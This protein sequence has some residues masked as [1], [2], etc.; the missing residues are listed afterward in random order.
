MFGNISISTDRGQ[1][2]AIGGNQVL[3]TNGLAEGSTGFGAGGAYVFFDITVSKNQSFT[4]S[5]GLILNNTIDT[6]GYNLLMNNT[7]S[8]VINGTLINNNTT[9]EL[10][11]NS[12]DKTNRHSDDFQLGHNITGRNF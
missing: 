10:N 1:D 2:Y 9:G 3:L 5:G 7:G 11:G 8:V 6:D 4:A 12:L